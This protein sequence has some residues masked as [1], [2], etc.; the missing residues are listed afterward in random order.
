MELSY[1]WIYKVLVDKIT[2]GIY[3]PWARQPVFL[4]IHE[5]TPHIDPLPTEH[6]TIMSY[7][8]SLVKKRHSDKEPD[9]WT[10]AFPFVTHAVVRS[11]V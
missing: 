1:I 7:L 10:A 9:A 6:A 5:S 3:T 4:S 2:K 8:D 11:S